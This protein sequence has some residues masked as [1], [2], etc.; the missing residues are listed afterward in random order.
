[1]VIAKLL[2]DTG[3]GLLLERIVEKLSDMYSN[4]RA[5]KQ[6]VFDKIDDYVL[7]GDNYFSSGSIRE[8]ANRYK[9]RLENLLDSYKNSIFET[10]N[11]YFAELKSLTNYIRNAVSQTSSHT[12]ITVYRAYENL[13]KLLGYKPVDVQK[14]TSYTSD[15]VNHYMEKIGDLNARLD[16]FLSLAS[17]FVADNTSLFKTASRRAAKWVAYKILESKGIPA[18]SLEKALSTTTRPFAE[19]GRKAKTLFVE[20]ESLVKKWNLAYSDFRGGVYGAV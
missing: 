13:C 3:K 7:K 9:D 10:I 18:D 5:S 17:G 15:L 6:A 20:Y 16:K 14:A 8:I 2:I 11:R 12:L 4:F 1:M 19:I